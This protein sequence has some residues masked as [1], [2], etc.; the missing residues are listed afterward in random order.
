MK[1]FSDNTKLANQIGMTIG[2][3]FLTAALALAQTAPPAAP[4]PPAPAAPQAA[5]AAPATP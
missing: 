1:N 5:P 4:T 2:G 3:L